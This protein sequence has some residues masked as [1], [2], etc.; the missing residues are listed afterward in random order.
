MD[1]KEIF[2]K[3]PIVKIMRLIGKLIRCS[4]GGLTKEEALDLLE[5]LSSISFDIAE[6]FD[7]LP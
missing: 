5:D 4:K 6:R 7:R 2:L 1:G 3:L